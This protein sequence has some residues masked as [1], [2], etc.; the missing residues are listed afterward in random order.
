MNENKERKQNGLIIPLILIFIFITA[1]VIYV[2][3]LMYKVAVSNS[4]A[5]MEDRILTV[6]AMI[7]NH[8]NTA[9]NVLHVAGDSVHHMLISGTTTARIH[10]FLV[11]ET[12]NVAEQFD[13]NYTGLY[14]YIMGKYIDGLNWVP[15]EGYDPK[16]RDWFIVAKEAGGD[17][18]FSP[19]YIDAQTGN[20]IISACR[21]LPDK[22]SVIALDVQ[23]KGIQT[24]MSVLTISVIGY[25]FFF[26]DNVFI[27]E[28][29]N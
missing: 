14:G 22:Q 19:P 1:M 3:S 18:V 20:L 27:I 6:S 2:S 25:G 16:T 13:E 11:D 4:N 5:V 29:I 23:L 9:E 8:V 17:V 12:V 15:P 28:H 26:D 21:M 7:T 24:M 10:E